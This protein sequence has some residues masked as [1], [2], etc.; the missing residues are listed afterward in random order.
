MKLWACTYKMRFREEDD[1]FPSRA[2]T[3]IGEFVQRTSGYSHSNLYARR[4]RLED[5]P[6][7]TALIDAAGKWLREE[8]GTKQWNEPWPSESAR[9]ERIRE[10]VENGETYVVKDDQ[11]VVAT[12][13]I[14]SKADPALWNIDRRAEPAIYLHR[15]AVKRKE[16]Y[17]GLGAGLVNWVVRRSVSREPP[18]L[19][20]RLDAWSDN[21]DLHGYY[22]SQ[23]FHNVDFVTPENGSPSGA[24]FQVPIAAHTDDGFFSVVGTRL[25]VKQA[26]LSDV[27]ALRGLL[28]GMDSWR[29]GVA[30]DR[31][32][33]ALGPTQSAR[34]EAIR[35]GIRGRK[36]W[37]VWDGAIPAAAVAMGSRNNEIWHGES[38]SAPKSAFL[39]WVAVDDGYAAKD[40]HR[41]IVLWAAW[42]MQ[43][44]NPSAEFVRTAA[45]SWDSGTQD[46]L[47]AIG[48]EM[49]KGRVTAEIEVKK[50]VDS[51]E[52]CVRQGF[53]ELLGYEIDWTSNPDD[54]PPFQGAVL[55]AFPAEGRMGGAPRKAE[56]NAGVPK[57]DRKPPS[58]ER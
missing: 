11:E 18:P 1:Y 34:E 7:I 50:W 19:Y 24:L 28:D 25:R 8:K 38:G 27:S 37:I 39:D 57:Q 49:T 52:Q 56:Q 53:G 12:V 2:P 30:Q 33:A 6:A 13:T 55:K 58:V 40:L 47:S 36:T 22:Q 48:F 35:K 54:H 9:A 17:K 51:P 4:A 21:R 20:V 23:G 3:S 41:N 42:Q 31:I 32:P 5:I 16:E 29:I 46:A 14:K 26:R 15:L 43:K 10:G 45:W 44:T